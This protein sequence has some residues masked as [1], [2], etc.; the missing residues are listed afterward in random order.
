MFHHFSAWLHDFLVK[1]LPNE[2]L[3]TFP[4]LLDKGPD[5]FRFDLF[6]TVCMLDILCLNYGKAFPYSGGGGGVQG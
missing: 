5:I 1:V 3:T 6:C 4:F 2:N